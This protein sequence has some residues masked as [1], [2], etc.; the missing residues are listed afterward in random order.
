MLFNNINQIEIVKDGKEQEMD[1]ISR[2]IYETRRWSFCVMGDE[3]IEQMHK[4]H[5]DEDWGN[6]AQGKFK[7]MQNNFGDWYASLDDRHRRRLTTIIY[8][9]I[10]NDKLTRWEGKKK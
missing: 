9:R 6:Y 5:K 7:M 3:Y 2:V 4:R 1:K 8:E 10:Y